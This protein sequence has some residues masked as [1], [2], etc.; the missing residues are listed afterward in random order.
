MA[1]TSALPP[2]DNLDGSEQIAVVQ[3]GES[4]K[5]NIGAYVDGR[6]GNMRLVPTD[7]FQY[8][9]VLVD[10]DNQ[11]IFKVERRGAKILFTA[12][13]GC[14]IGIG[15]LGQDTLAKMLP[16]QATLV[17]ISSRTSDWLFPLRDAAGNILSGSVRPSGQGVYNIGPESIIDPSVISTALAGADLSGLDYTLNIEGDSLSGAQIAPAVPWGTMLGAAIGLPVSG[18]PIGGSSTGSIAVRLGAKEMLLTLAGDIPAGGT[19]VDVTAYSEELMDLNQGP[20]QEYPGILA[21]TAVI[22]KR[23]SN[24]PGDIT[25]T[26]LKYTIRR[27]VAGAAVTVPAGS[28]FYPDM[29]IGKQKRLTIIWAGRNNDM[30]THASRVAA[31]DDIMRMADFFD[32]EY[33]AFMERTNAAGEGIGTNA[34]DNNLEFNLLLRNALTDRH[35]IRQR[36]YL[37]SARALQ[38]AGLISGAIADDNGASNPLGIGATDL[39]NI[40]DDIPLDSLRRDYVHYNEYGNIVIDLYAERWW[41]AQNWPSTLGVS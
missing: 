40:A 16:D 4:R 33:F 32:H 38:D 9:M 24:P 19:E 12:A 10:S 3:D 18:N 15:A 7:S 14:N 27:A 35:L 13:D 21:E 37:C 5:S 1:K 31:L 30:S 34:Y 6:F 2:A 8:A 39:A 41:R 29:A 28:R 25:S 23:Y 36:S 22:I 11:V 20:T 26:T 17:P